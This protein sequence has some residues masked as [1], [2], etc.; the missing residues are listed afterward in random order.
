MFAS[1]Q[2]RTAI[3]TGATRGIGKGIAARFG[4]AGMNVVV[5]GRNQA[6]AERAAADIGSNAIAWAADITQFGATQSMARE[7]ERRYGR[8]DVLCANAGIFPR[9]RIDEMSVS[10]FDTMM[11][12]NLRGTFLSVSAC[13]PAMKRQQ[14]GRIVIVGSITGTLGGYPGCSHYGASKAG[15]LGFMRSAAIELAPWNITVNAVLPGNVRT[16]SQSPEKTAYQ[17]QKIVMSPMRRLAAV[18]DIANGA[19]FFSSQ[20]AGAITGQSLVID[21]GQSLPESPSA[22]DEAMAAAGRV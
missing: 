16:D 12:V 8:I 20:E 11:A 21:A 3:V 1:L 17:Q 18:E 10:D 13:L 19:L 4:E 5:V 2:G 14:Q 9:A 6:D 15:Q 7:V 22:V